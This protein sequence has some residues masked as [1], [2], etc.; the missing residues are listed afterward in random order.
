MSPFTEEQLAALIAA[1]PPAPESWVQAASELPTA[2]AAIDGIVAR[3]MHADA[4]RVAILADLEGALRSEGVEPVPA[5]VARLRD[6]LGA[7]AE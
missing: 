5:L 3:A 7:S 1:L 2:R 6:L 4:V